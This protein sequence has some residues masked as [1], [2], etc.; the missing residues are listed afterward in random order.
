MNG[1]LPHRY[2]SWGG[3][4]NF[5]AHSLLVNF[6]ASIYAMCERRGSATCLGLRGRGTAE[7]QLGYS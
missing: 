2:C 1:I 3:G 6:E 7:A 5:N 4:G